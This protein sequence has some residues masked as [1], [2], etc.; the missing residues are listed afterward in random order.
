M[1]PGVQLSKRQTILLKRLEQLCE[2]AEK[3]VLP[4]Y[5]EEIR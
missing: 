3:K 5:I 1:P 2:R 4:V